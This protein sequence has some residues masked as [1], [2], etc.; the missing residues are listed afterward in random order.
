MA[1]YCNDC[2]YRGKVSGQGG[3]C[4]AC[5]SFNV[6]VGRTQT[7]EQEGPPPWHKPALITSWAL[8]L[9]LIAWKLIS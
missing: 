6:S 1:Y 3:Q 4:P 5:G 8:L 7:E 9:I 2:S